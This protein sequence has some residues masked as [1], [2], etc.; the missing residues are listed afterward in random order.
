M[1]Y[2]SFLWYKLKEKSGEL[3]IETILGI[4]LAVIIAGFVLIPGLRSFAQ[5]VLTSM[6]SWWDNTVKSGIFPTS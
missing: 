4:A 5:S 1:N 6:T 3:G 2:L